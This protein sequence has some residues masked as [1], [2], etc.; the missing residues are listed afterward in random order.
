MTEFRP[1]SWN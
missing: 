1:R